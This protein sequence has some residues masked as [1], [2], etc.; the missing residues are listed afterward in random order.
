MKDEVNRKSAEQ[1]PQ[2]HKLSPTETSELQ[3]KRDGVI[4]SSAWLGARLML[5]MILVIQKPTLAVLWHMRRHYTSTPRAKKRGRKPTPTNKWQAY[6]L[7]NRRE[8]KC[9]RCGKPC[10]PFAACADCRAKKARHCYEAY[11]LK[12]D[13]SAPNADISRRADSERGRQKGLN[14]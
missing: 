7:K 10:A 13:A 14:D 4:R 6:R 1:F 11:L 2:S 12:P 9:P 5:W 8:G 3:V